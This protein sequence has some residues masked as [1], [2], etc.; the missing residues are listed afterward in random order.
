MSDAW[1]PVLDEL[2]GTMIPEFKARVAE[3]DMSG[4]TVSD[5]LEIADAVPDLIDIADK[6]LDSVEGL[7]D[8]DERELFIHGLDEAIKLPI[9]AE[10]FD[11][12]VLGMIY[13]F[14]QAKRKKAA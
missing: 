11:D 8:E 2:R 5:I 14:V 3:I 12:N 1:K 4:D 6:Y 9:W 7:S 13:D 10:A